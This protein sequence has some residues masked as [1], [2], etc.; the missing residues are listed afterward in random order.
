MHSGL[1]EP[2]GRIVRD[3]ARSGVGLR[4]V[5]ANSDLDGLTNP[6][7]IDRAQGIPRVHQLLVRG[8]R[9]I[10]HGWG[11]KI[12]GR[13]TG[14]VGWGKSMFP[15]LHAPRMGGVL[16]RTAPVVVLPLHQYMAQR[17]AQIAQQ[18]CRDVPRQSRIPGPAAVAE[19]P[20]FVRE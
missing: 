18:R 9:A 8:W 10:S 7:A 1:T 2:R 11:G 20:P 14:V 12:R 17:R 19:A 4:E 3:R 13:P 16:G 5:V 6:V 15:R